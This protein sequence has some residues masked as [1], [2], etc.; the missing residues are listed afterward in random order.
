MERI[1]GRDVPPTPPHVPWEQLIILTECKTAIVNVR[2][3]LTTKV[4]WQQKAFFISLG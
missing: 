4:F 3:L 1:G 2:K